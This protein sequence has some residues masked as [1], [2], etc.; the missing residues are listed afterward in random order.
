MGIFPNIW[1]VVPRRINEGW[2]SYDGKSLAS[3]MSAWELEGPLLTL[4]CGGNR[5]SG[6]QV[7]VYVH[8]ECEDVVQGMDPGV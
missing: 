1:T 4:V 7:K 5:L 2:R 6:K 8:W 3:K